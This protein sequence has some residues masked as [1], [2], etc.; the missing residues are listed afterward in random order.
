MLENKMNSLIDFAL[1]LES[2]DV[3]INM[4]I[5]FR[6]VLAWDRRSHC[7]PETNC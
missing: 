4:L 5:L 6:L 7:K 2:Y 1:L 3:Q